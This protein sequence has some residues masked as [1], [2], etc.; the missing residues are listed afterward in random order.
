MNSGPCD[1]EL[2]CIHLRARVAELQTDLSVSRQSYYEVVE[3]R[4]DV[5]ARIAS[6]EAAARALVDSWDEPRPSQPFVD[7]LR[8]ALA[9]EEGA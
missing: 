6:L 8:K 5:L 9:G 2:E 4:N 3:Q 1:Y 7:A